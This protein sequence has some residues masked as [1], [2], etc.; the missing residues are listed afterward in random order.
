[1]Q[2]DVS[3]AQ[4]ARPTPTVGAARR[5]RPLWQVALAAW[6]GQRLLIGALVVAWQLLLQTFSPAAFYRVWTLFDGVYYSLIARYGY[7]LLPGYR[8]LQEAA[9]FPLYPLL[10]RVTAPLV[11]GHVTLAGLIL[12]NLCSLAAFLLLGRLVARECG[13]QVARRTLL[14]YAVFPTGF[15]LAAVY[16]EALFLLLSVAAFL[17]MRQRR[18]L[19][20]GALI[21]LAT[22]ARAQGALLLPLVI[23]AWRALLPE[24][25]T[26]GGARRLREGLALACAIAAPLLAL[27]AFQFYLAHQYGVTDAMSRAA[28]NSDWLRYPDWPWAGVVND[29]ATLATGGAATPTLEIIKD[30]VFLAFWL[31]LCVV[32]LLRFRPALP[33]SWVAYSWVSL[34]EML[35]LPA[36]IRG[37]GL[38][39][40]PRY[41]LVVF[42][43]FAL[44]ALI[45]VRYPRA[46]RLT[47]ALC[48]AW[49]IILTRLLAGAMFVA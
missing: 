3:V 27:L 11:G 29:I 31:G 7:Q 41:A 22:L 34:L 6:L 9:Y 48:I 33:W 17:C 38:M 19:L 36:H 40:V 26:L 46:H 16:T 1:M 24:W 39:S 42:P 35:A 28:D 4:A 30:F 12:A 5:E 44:L 13:P 2:A 20:C 32:M 25:R 15:F 37:G 18:W 43:C 21:A 47:V 49:T 8:S 14:Y 10:M 23:E 45:G